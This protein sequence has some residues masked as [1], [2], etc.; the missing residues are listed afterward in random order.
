MKKLTFLFVL[1]LLGLI[2]LK[3]QNAQ[4]ELNGNSTGDN[5]HLLLSET[6]TSDFARM[7]FLNANADGN[8][9]GLVGKPLPDN[10]TNDAEFNFFY[11]DSI[12]NVLQLFGSGDATIKGNLTEGSDIR[13]K[14]NLVPINSVLPQLKQLNGYRYNWKNSRND[15]LQIGLVA[16]EVKKLFPELVKENSEGFLSVNYSKFVPI[17]IEGFKELEERNE[18]SEAE[19]KELKSRLVLLEKMVGQR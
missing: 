1:P 6:G 9:W 17:L 10:Q 11:S 2:S 12:F 13:L 7:R 8:Y 5:P 4:L 19:I 16:Q 14:E 18:A 15:Q 3:A